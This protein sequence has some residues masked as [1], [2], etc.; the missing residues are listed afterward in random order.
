MALF[1]LAILNVINPT[2]NAAGIAD[3]GAQAG[4][5]YSGDGLS[6]TATDAGAQ[7]HCI[8]QKLTGN[9]TPQGL[10]LESTTG[11]QERFGV[12]ASSVG[13][14]KSSSL[15]LAQSGQVEIQ[16]KT[17]QFRRP[18]LVEEYS[19]SVDGL[20][21]DFV[22]LQKPAG[23]G[24][25][26]VQLEVTGAKIESADYGAR[27]VLDKSGR[28]IAYSRL[29]A[30]DATGKELSAT[31]APLAR[32]HKM[33]VRV[34]D[35]G[36]V[37]PVRIDPTFS[38]ANWVSMGGFAGVNLQVNAIT[39]DSA[40]HLFVGGSFSAAGN[41]NASR[42]AMWNGTN[43]LKLAKGINNDVLSLTTDN[44]NLYAGG[45]FTYITNLDNS[46]IHASGIAKW[47]GTNWSAMGLGVGGFGG[48]EMVAA[49]A[50]QGGKV[51]AGGKFF[52]VTNTVGGA[53]TYAHFIAQWDINSSTW[54]A[55]GG[56]VSGN[57]FALA[58]SG[59]NL[60]VGGE[61][62]GFYQPGSENSGTIVYQ[63]RQMEWDKVVHI[64]KR[65]V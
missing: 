54:S 22:V 15:N 21:Q 59:T 24:E 48:V 30:T 27:L 6:V 51:Y 23:A 36:A 33:V 12:K 44:T 62:G 18:G 43:W 63:H 55:L 4:A 39:M 41:T 11:S 49:L 5:N 26:E 58:V 7:L 8:F 37:Y 20:R 40:G 52:Y 25:L 57:V 28:K 31:I 47:D 35:E 32:T 14:A 29:K 2:A 60:Y 53:V 3:I 56:G 61:F 13:R 10:S 64:G 42:I 1:V 34:Q 45:Y 9:V 65:G 17:V 46:V 19:V 38:D 16:E 50:Y